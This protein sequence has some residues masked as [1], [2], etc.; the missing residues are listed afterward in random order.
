MGR[1]SKAST[2]RLANLTKA[3][4]APKS[5]KVTVEDV[6]ES[7]SEDMEYDPTMDQQKNTFE[8]EFYF[9]EDLFDK[10]DSEDL[11]EVDCVS[12]SDLEMMWDERDEEEIQDDA[13]LLNF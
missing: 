6:T 7:D 3:A 4:A 5:H 11:P 13:A 10:D 2:A 8:G 12:D 9:M 1:I